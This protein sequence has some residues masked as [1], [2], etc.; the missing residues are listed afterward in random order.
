LPG[1][2][3]LNNFRIRNLNVNANFPELVALIRRNKSQILECKYHSFK[4]SIHTHPL[5]S[6]VASC[7]AAVQPAS[8]EGAGLGR[9][10]YFV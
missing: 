4:S 3:L 5:R 9:G 6:P 10:I 1:N 2:S 8:R 7:I